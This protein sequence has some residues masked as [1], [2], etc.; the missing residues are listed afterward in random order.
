MLYRGPGTGSDQAARGGWTASQPEAGHQAV[1][2]P[3]D[4]G[5]EVIIESLIDHS[6]VRTSYII[7]VFAYGS[8]FSHS[9]REKNVPISIYILRQYVCKVSWRSVE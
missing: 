4:V 3:R 9:S 7:L 5:P 6:D 8:R 2:E 1:Y